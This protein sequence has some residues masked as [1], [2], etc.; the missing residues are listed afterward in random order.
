MIIGCC[1]NRDHKMI[2]YILA[3][4]KVALPG[5]RASRVKVKERACEPC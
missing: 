2:A 5:V 1:V 4:N 3:S